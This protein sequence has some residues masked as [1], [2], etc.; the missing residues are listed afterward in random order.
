M[1]HR[2]RRAVYDRLEAVG[3]H[4]GHADAGSLVKL[5]RTEIHRL[6]RCWRQVLAAHQPDEDGR[7]PLCSGLFR[8]RRWP[9]QVWLAAHQ[10]LI[11]EGLAHK[12]RPNPL[13]SPF[14]P[15]VVAR[16]VPQ[17]IE[18]PLHAAS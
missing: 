15:V 13:P 17:P 8:R 4:A 3:E 2:L 9:C 18:L 11:G 1:G 6:T 10:Q 12:E 7:C 5:A 14:A 16:R